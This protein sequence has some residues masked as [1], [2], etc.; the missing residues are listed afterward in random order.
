M[1]AKLSQ[2]EKAAEAKKKAELELLLDEDENAHEAT[3][4]FDMDEIQKSE[5]IEHTFR[6][7]R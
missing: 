2:E 3:R 6:R 4:G 1:R 7:A 5:V